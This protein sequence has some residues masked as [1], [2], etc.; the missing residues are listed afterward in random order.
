[1][2]V[3]IALLSALLLISH[4]ANIYKAKP[5]LYLIGD[6][7]VAS[8]STSNPIQGWGGK[9]NNFFYSD[10]TI[11]NRSVSG[12]SS[13]TYQTGIVHRP[14]LLKNGMWKSIMQTLKAGDFVLMQ[15]GHNDESPTADTSRMRGS[16]K[17]VGDDSIIVFNRFSNS[18]EAVYSYGHYL[19]KFIA[20]I[21][22]KGATAIICSPIPKNKWVNNK[23]VRNNDD[24]GKW[25]KEVAK[26]T[27]A[28][29][30][31]LNQLV[32][33][34]YDRLGQ[35]KVKSTYFV[36]DGV[37]TTQTGA[38]MNAKIVASALKK[39]SLKPYLNI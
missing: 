33:D 18:N 3:K 14:D 28:F 38:E 6:S 37:H 12:I 26:Q 19:R 23:V 34:E 9:L 29:F 27:G 1:M 20:D 39:S 4:Q 13:R 10:L 2:N 32:A 22:S 36:P 5:I 11:E 7:T 8:A 16:L 35:E 24:Y 21:K 31:D 17:G 15:F 25:A 30:I